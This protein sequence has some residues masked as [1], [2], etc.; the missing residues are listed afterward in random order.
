MNFLTFKSAIAA[1]FAK[2]QQNPLFRV[3]IPSDALWANYL[4]SFPPGANPIFR[5]RAEYDCSCCRSFV[6]NI[7]GAV[8]IIDGKL[9]SIWDIVVPEPAF[10]IV[11]DSMATLVKGAKIVDAFYHFQKT[12]GTDR[13]F[14]QIIDA[15]GSA[16]KAGVM[17]WNHFFVN[18]LP[19]HV[20]PN[21]DI[22]TK[23]GEIRQAR[24]VLHRSLVEISDEAIATVLDLIAQN[25]LYRG[26]ENRF[27]VSQF[28]SL[29]G[30]FNRLSD[31]EKELFSWTVRDISSVIKIR[32]TAI[33]TLLTDLSE[34]KDLEF[35]V[36]SFEAKVAPT[37]YKRPTSLVT[38]AMVDN[39]K[40]QLEALGLTSA[41]QRRYA[42]EADL[43]IN[44]VLFADRSTK[45]AGDI[46]DMITPGQSAKNLD[47][48][49][50]MNIE[51][52]IAD[53]LPRI[54]SLEVM[55][56]NGHDANF[57]SLIAPSDPTAG[58]LFKWSNNFS[59]SYAGGVADSIK[60][61]VKQAGGSVSGDLC[62]RLSWFNHDDLDFHMQEPGYEIAYPNKGHLSPSGGM[63]DVDMNAGGGRTRTPVENIFY[64]SQRGMKEGVYTLQVHNF[65]KRETVDVGFEV[66]IEI[67][68]QTYN[69]AHPKAVGN[70]DTV[71]VAQ[72]AYSKKDGVKLITALP[73]NKVSHTVWGV[74]TN[75]FQ[76]VNLFLLSPNHWDG[77]GVGNKHYF[78]VLDKCIS[79]VPARG[80][81]NEFLKS[82][83]DKHRKVFEVLGSKLVVPN[84]DFQLS[85]LG[86]SSTQRNSLVCRVSGSFTRTLRVMF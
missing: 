70:R 35:A 52:F 41:L 53:V 50:E 16:D 11:A 33:G 63:L 13:N 7:G 76:K 18:I 62:C 14:E 21:K 42:T 3:D 58:A 79:D 37:N 32:N 51:K 84:S 46:F 17:T 10:Q 23:L 67:L 30:Q 49:E 64:K 80:F 54:T 5:K 26:E 12:A 6:K 39:A 48:I 44:N 19:S 61:R 2:M 27:A 71:T 1:Q 22:A 81:L 60:E 4:A 73:E 28:Q 38:K 75:C 86:F 24:G 15:S 56:E 25:S 85:G 45:L 74:S 83:L 66:E 9:V 77:Q 82:E 40:T 68:G 59:W 69:F 78:F 57:V 34:G 72:F 55:P 43:T 20:L 47:K 36:K 65:S 29:K 8:A 31:S